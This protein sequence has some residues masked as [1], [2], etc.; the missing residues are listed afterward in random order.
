MENFI[1]VFDENAR[2]QLLSR[3]CEMLGQNSEKHI[4]VFLNTG[5]LNFEYGD[6]RY[7]LSN[8]LTF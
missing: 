5:N 6:I 2:D 3:G 7:V 4:F 8:T 1:Y